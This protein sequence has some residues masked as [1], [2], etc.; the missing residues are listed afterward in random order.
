[1]PKLPFRAGS[2]ERQLDVP[3]RRRSVAGPWFS[4]RSALNRASATTIFSFALTARVGLRY[5]IRTMHLSEVAQRRLLHRAP[6]QG[7]I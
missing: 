4:P 2:D 7:R 3:V 6:S 5:T 1:M